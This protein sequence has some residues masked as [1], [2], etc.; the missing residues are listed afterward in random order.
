[1]KEPVK[2]L[3]RGVSSRRTFLQTGVIGG[4]A[5]AIYPALGAARVVA[6]EDSS[7]K[8]APPEIPP[9]ELEEM[10][11]DQLQQYRGAPVYSDNG[12]KLGTVEELFADYETD[13]PEWI[14][15]PVA[16]IERLMQQATEAI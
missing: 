1:M 9:F 8:S 16:G 7:P 12:E 4:A 6:A 2:N 5:A 13:R 15:I 10:T 3:K 11:I 14:G